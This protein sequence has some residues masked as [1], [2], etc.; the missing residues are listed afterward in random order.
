MNS[1]NNVYIGLRPKRKQ[2]KKKNPKSAPYLNRK[3]AIPKECFCPICLQDVD[4]NSIATIPS[5]G[6]S[7]CVYCIVQ[8]AE[9][10]LEP[11]CPQCKKKFDSLFLYRKLDGSISSESI[12]ESICLIQRA[13]WFIT[14]KSRVAMVNQFDPG[15]VEDED[16]DDDYF[17]GNE[18]DDVEDFYFSNAAGSARIVLS[19]RKFGKNGYVRSGRVFAQTTSSAADDDDQKQ[20]SDLV[21][22]DDKAPKER[23]TNPKGQRARRREDKKKKDANR[24]V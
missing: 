10:K 7:Y 18:I 19:N 11:T 1:T 15:H 3:D 17:T 9:E 6:H 2:R 24:I 14:H 5:C 4:K 12:Q 8:W 22:A 20:N 21:E 16:W 23:K 13:H